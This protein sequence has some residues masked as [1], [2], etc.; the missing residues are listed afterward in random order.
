MCYLEKTNMKQITRLFPLVVTVLF[1]MGAAPGKGGKTTG[2]K[3]NPSDRLPITA[4]GGRLKADDAKLKEMVRTVRLPTR[5]VWYLWIR[6]TAKSNANAIIAY[7]LDGRGYRS[8]RGRIVVQPSAKSQWYSHSAYPEFNAEVHADKPGNYELKLS[9]QYGEVEIDR[10]ALTLFFS[11][12]PKGDILDHTGDPGGGTAVFPDTSDRA[13]GFRPDWTSPP[14]KADRLI[15]VDA[16]DGNDSA[17]GLTPATAWKSFRNANGRDFKPGDALLL[18]RGCEWEEGLAPAGNGSATKW[19]TIGA[20]GT[21]RRP[22]INGINRDAVRLE[23]ASYWVVQ[24]LELTS[25]PGYKRCGLKVVT[26]AGKPQPRG[27]RIFNII[28]YDNGPAGILVGSDHGGGNG[29]DGVLIE[30]CLSYAHDSDG[31]LVC[32]SDQNGCRNSVIRHSTAYS[33]L[34]GGG[35]WIQSGQNGLIEHCL[36]YNNACINIWTWNSINVT[37]RHCESFRGRT[38]RDAGGFDIDWGC[39]ACT[40]EYCYSH[41]NEGVGILLMGGGDGTYRNFPVHS[42]YNL[43]RF[44]VTMNDSPGIGLVETFEDCIV[45]NNLSVTTG[46]KRGAFDISGWPTSPWDDVMKA[47]GWPARTEFVN[48][49]FV[50]RAG[51]LPSYVDD[52]SATKEYANVFDN[53]LYWRDTPGPLVR[54]G[55][56]KNGTGFWTGQKSSDLTPPRNFT[57]LKDFSRTTGQETGGISS[58]PRFVA[59]YGGEYGRLPLESCRLKESSPVF[60]KGKEIVL[61]KEWLDGRAKFL[62]ETGAAEYGIPMAP[63]TATV[64]YWGNPLDSKAYPIGPCAR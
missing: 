32:G 30:N 24:D 48:N 63:A 47:G 14:V 22:V 17:D 16:R 55:G 19:I 18:K 2:A 44:N 6:A 42:F 49:V 29:Y 43:A 9:A 53:N 15:H 3:K 41:H 5:G 39:E 28:A 37:M 20:Y 21:G 60:G 8:Q 35:I 59:P 4:A 33:N 51:A 64:D 7:S 38:P 1:L 27:I 46:K 26:A 54:W 50:G 56:R 10:I 11:A 12:K 31:I 57:S 45:H 13:D 34:Y 36:A 62:T 61:S 52:W 23:E 40:L 25:D 58:E